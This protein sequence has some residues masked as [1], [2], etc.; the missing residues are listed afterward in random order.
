MSIRNKYRTADIHDVM[1]IERN[2]DCDFN[3][4][5][6]TLAAVYAKYGY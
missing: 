4:E 2:Y 6:S 1:E 3:P 5:P